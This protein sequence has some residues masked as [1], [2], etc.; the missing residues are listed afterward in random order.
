VIQDQFEPE[1]RFG[2]SVPLQSVPR[3]QRRD[4]ILDRI[5]ESLN[6]KGSTESEWNMSQLARAANT[7]RV[8]LYQYFGDVEGV[9]EAVR[10]RIVGEVETIVERLDRIPAAE[11]R[12]RAVSTW[13]GWIDDNRELAIRTLLLEEAAPAFAIFAEENRVML[14]RQ[15]SRIFLGVEEPSRGLIRQLEVYVGAAE[16]TLRR[17]LLDGRMERPE[18]VEAFNRLLGDVIRMG[19]ERDDVPKPLPGDR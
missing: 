6:E 10:T 3:H 8:T 11:Q 14:L 13:M 17:W 15:V 18:V 7:S 4:V 12:A 1:S 5:V 16:H 9:R 19:A 2:G